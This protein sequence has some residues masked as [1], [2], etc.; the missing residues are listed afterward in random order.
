LFRAQCIHLPITEA[1][2]NDTYMLIHSSFVHLILPFFTFD[3]HQV[4]VN[5][6]NQLYDTLACNKSEKLNRYQTS[7]IIESPF[8]PRSYP[9]ASSCIVDITAPFGFRIV[10]NFNNFDLEEEE[11]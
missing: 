5:E 6:E 2:Q 9:K 3:P 1:D 4:N 7:I 11:E 8:Y 10:L